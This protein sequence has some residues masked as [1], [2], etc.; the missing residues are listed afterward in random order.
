MF[1][2]RRAADEQ[3]RA[4]SRR[5]VQRQEQQVRPGAGQLH[6]GPGEPGQA[7]RGYSRGD[8]REPAEQDV[9]GHRRGPFPRVGV[10]SGHG[11]GPQQCITLKLTFYGAFINSS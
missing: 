11:P 1:M 9:L 5:A 8:R 10:L 2:H 7:L 3:Y 6:V 4:D